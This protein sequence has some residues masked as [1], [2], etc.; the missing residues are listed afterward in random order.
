MIKVW[1]PFVR[2]FHWSLVIA[3]IIQWITAESFTRVHV[4]V[5]YLVGLLLLVRVIWGFIG[6]KHAR[7]SDFI[8]S[9]RQVFGYLKSLSHRNPK[10]YIG[11]SPAGGAMVMLLLL[12]LLLTV[13]AGLKT[14]GAKGQGPLASLPAAPV[15][16][17]YAD[18]DDIDGDEARE[19]D[20]G[21][22][23][24]ADYWKDIHE[25]LASTVIFLGILHVGGVLTVSLIHKENLIIAM[26]N[27]KKPSRDIH[28]ADQ[29][30]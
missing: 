2:I 1:D 14:L 5:G 21:N 28:S 11:H 17:V 27:G 20:T 8:Y 4:W 26:I 16:R 9:P 10:H 18:E 13:A 7:F 22:H 30:K 19:K 24:A 15:S 25:V 29:G 12:V 3:I 23:A 6:S